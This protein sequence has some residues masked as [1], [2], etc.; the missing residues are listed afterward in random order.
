MRYF[1][2]IAMSLLLTGCGMEARKSYTVNAVV[3][4]MWKTSNIIGHTTLHGSFVFTIN[5]HVFFKEVELTPS[6]YSYCESNKENIEFQVDFFYDNEVGN[7]RIKITYYL[8][9][10]AVID[11]TYSN[12]SKNKFL[13]YTNNFIFPGMT[14][15]QID[16]YHHLNYKGVIDFGYLVGVVLSFILIMC[17]IVSGTLSSHLNYIGGIPDRWE[18]SA[19][20]KEMLKFNNLEPQDM[21]PLIENGTYNLDDITFEQKRRFIEAK[22][23]AKYEGLGELS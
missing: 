1:I 2:I 18:A 6:Q 21:I 7:S 12:R 4:K 17:Y 13:F 11:E 8:L 20:K 14:T 5:D 22:I 23:N 9:G 15:A 10:N 19:K 3:E 16:E